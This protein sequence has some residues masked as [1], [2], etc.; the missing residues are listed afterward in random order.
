MTVTEV[1]EEIAALSLQGPTSATV[2]KAG[3]L[4]RGR[5][6]TVPNVVRMPSAR[7]RSPI[8][9]TGF[10]GDLGYELWTTPDQALPL[11]DRLFEA[12]SLYGIAPIGTDALNIARIE[13]GFIITNMDFMPAD[14][15]LREDRPARR[16]KW[17][18]AG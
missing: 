15:A 3:R 6:E 9:R 5:P 1:T 13:A 7:A 10:T 11:W 12:G 8:S 4:R 16:S 17:D 14:Q 18:W 2:L